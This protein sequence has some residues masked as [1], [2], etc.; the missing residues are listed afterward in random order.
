MTRKQQTRSLK[1]TGR[2]PWELA[3]AV[4]RFEKIKTVYLFGPPGSG[5]TYGALHF[6][7]DP[8]D[9]YCVTLTEETPASELR[10][11]YMIREGSFVWSDGPFVRA[12]REGKRLVINELQHA[13]ADVL[14]LLFPILESWETARLTLPTGETVRPQDGFRVIATD[15]RPPDGLPEPLQDRFA[16]TLRVTEPHPNALASLNEDLQ[17]AARSSSSLEDGRQISVRGWKALQ[18]LEPVFGLLDGCSLAF[19]PDSGPLV[20]DALVMAR[21]ARKT[22]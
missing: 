17:G 14:A 21:N 7:V 19:G 11:S 3:E 16:V 6:G 8:D 5:K 18:M 22:S 20:H 9:V 15:N 13:G 2:A 4:I 10:G 1:K 12:M